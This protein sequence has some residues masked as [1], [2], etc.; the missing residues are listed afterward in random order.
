MKKRSL[1]K[2]AFLGLASGLLMIE[3]ANAAS[4]SGLI[5]EVASEEILAF[6]KCKGPNGCPGQIAQE[7]RKTHSA[8]DFK[9][10]SDSDSDDVD[11]NSS[12]MG[13]HLMT[14]DELLLELN[15]EGVKTYNSLSPEGKKMALEVASMRC[16]Q[17]NLCK[18]LNACKTQTNDC[19]GKG[20]C[21]AQ[22]KCAHADKNLAVKLVAEKMARKRAELNK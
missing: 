13:Y 1:K 12:N 6:K 21:K 20:P 10:S 5:P 17:T 19:A 15:D 3:K 14:E 8:T 16:A 7:D 22:G 2:L 9:D 11:P 18:G 4:S